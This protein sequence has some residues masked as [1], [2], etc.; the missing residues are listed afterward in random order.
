M[1]LGTESLGLLALAEFVE[2]EAGGSPADEAAAVTV[3]DTPVWVVE[4]KALFPGTEEALVGF[5][6]S[7]GTGWTT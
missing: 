1:A 3:T 4:I 2:E 6:F 5:F 7:D